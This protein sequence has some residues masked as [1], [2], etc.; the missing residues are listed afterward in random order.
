MSPI[1]EQLHE[2]RKAQKLTQAQLGKRLGWAQT[3]VST[4]EKGRVD[5]RLSSVVQMA[6]LVDHELML[7][8]KSMLPAIQAMLSGKTEE[9][10]WTI[11]DEEESMP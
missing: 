9:P 1:T 4:I 7:V 11:G 5:P 2:A 10:L 6:R 3:R 8:P